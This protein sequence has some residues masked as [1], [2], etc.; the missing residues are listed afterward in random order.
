MAT[1]MKMMGA[2]LTQFMIL[3][4]QTPFLK[5]LVQKYQYTVLYYRQFKI[6]VDRLG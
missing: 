1:Q 5:N 4:G 3:G 6:Y 2:Q